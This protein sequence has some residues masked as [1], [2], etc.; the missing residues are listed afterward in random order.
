N[1]IYGNTTENRGVIGN[2]I[3]RVFDLNCASVGLNE[4]TLKAEGR[5]YKFVYG[6]FRDRVQG[7]LPI[8]MKLIFEDP[9]GK[10]LGAQ[11]IGRGEVDKRIDVIATAIG[12]GG[13]IQDLWEN[14]LAYSPIYSTTKDP[15]NLLASTALNYLNGL[16]KKVSIPEIRK[17]V[18]LD[19]YFLD[20]RSK[21]AFERGHIKGA[22]NI[23]S[24][25]LKERLDELPKDK[26]IYNDSYSVVRML[27]QRGFENVY[28]VD[29]NFEDLCLY[30]YYKDKLK[31]R[32]PIV[33]E[34]RFV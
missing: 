11:I 15:T 21:N 19:S 31:R 6:T 32:E 22:V 24:K 29:G 26:R 23:P 27:S 30:E 14:E 9:T 34:Y 12:F 7:G 33:T 28:Y 2:S 25:E 20:T 17:L 18:E 1:H 13:T 3:L 5:K 16:M 10:I 4:R 8:H